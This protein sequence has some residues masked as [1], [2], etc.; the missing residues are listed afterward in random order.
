M[1]IYRQRHS[2]ARP[3]AG[4]RPETTV[5]LGDTLRE[6]IEKKISPR[7]ARFKAVSE[8]WG[9]LL[10]AELQRHCE[11]TDISGGRMKV[12]VESPVYAYELRLC[13]RELLGQLRTH[14]PQARIEKI[15]FVVGRVVSVQ[16]V[17]A[18]EAGLK[19]GSVVRRQ[20]IHERP[21]VRCE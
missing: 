21:Q 2:A 12:V 16:P 8:F 5:R 19:G 9:R 20:D 11:I 14:C 10:P 6:L 17:S 3:Q 7:R 15:N 13:S 1:D 4:R 18:E